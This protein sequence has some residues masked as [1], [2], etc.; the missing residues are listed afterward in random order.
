MLPDFARNLL[1]EPVDNEALDASNPISAFEWHRF[2][3][4]AMTCTQ[5]STTTIATITSQGQRNQHFDKDIFTTELEPEEDSQEAKPAEKLGL[6]EKAKS[7]VS[8]TTNGEAAAEDDKKDRAARQRKSFQ[9]QKNR[10]V[11]KFLRQSMEVTSLLGHSRAGEFLSIYIQKAVSK[12]ILC[13]GMTDHQLEVNKE[14]MAFVHDQASS[15]MDNK[16]M[17]NTNDEDLI[18]AVARDSTENVK[19]QRRLNTL[20]LAHEE[21]MQTASSSLCPRASSAGQKATEAF[22]DVLPVVRSMLRSEECRRQDNKTKKR[23]GTSSSRSRFIHYFDTVNVC[24]TE[25]HLEALKRPF[26]NYHS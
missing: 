3:M 5:D 15:E 16:L 2:H 10:D 25:T 21:A 1:K 26:F 18:M 20:H 24:L 23:Q 11:M 14:I 6:I 8:S 19:R 4:L 17:W 22:M 7:E 13:L 12:Y 9:T